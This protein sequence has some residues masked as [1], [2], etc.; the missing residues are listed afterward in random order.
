[1]NKQWNNL[2]FLVNE[3]SKIAFAKKK[4]AKFNKVAAELAVNS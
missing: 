2:S 1:M 4:L 3:K